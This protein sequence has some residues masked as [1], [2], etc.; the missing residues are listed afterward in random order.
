MTRLCSAE[1]P[2]SYHRRRIISEP[3]REAMR[4]DPVLATRL[5]I[6]AGPRKIG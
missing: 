5:A 2:A 3:R 1:N 4:D 6:S